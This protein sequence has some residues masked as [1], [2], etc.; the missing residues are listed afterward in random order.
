[1][2][3]NGSTMITSFICFQDPWHC[4]IGLPISS[5][6]IQ[7]LRKV[8]NYMQTPQNSTRE[9][10]GTISG[11]TQIHNVLNEEYYNQLQYDV[12]AC[13]KI[14]QLHH[15]Q[16]YICYTL[17]I[18]YGYTRL[19]RQIQYC[20]FSELDQDLLHMYANWNLVQI[21]N[22]LSVQ[23]EGCLASIFYNCLHFKLFE[24]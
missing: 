14:S 21:R 2:A 1:L 4:A 8:W 18:W 22:S 9:P 5:N 20:S 11:T 23:L 3:S 6:N 12:L 13:T 10:P 7:S 15:M 16:T 24:L 19:N 17:K